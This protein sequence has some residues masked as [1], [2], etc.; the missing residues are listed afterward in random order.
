VSIS[1]TLFCW[2]SLRN[3]FTKTLFATGCFYKSRTFLAMILQVLCIYAYIVNTLQRYTFSGYIQT[4]KTCSCSFIKNHSTSKLTKIIYIAKGK[5]QLQ[6]KQK[7]NIT[8]FEIIILYKHTC[9]VVIYITCCINMHCAGCIVL[10]QD[11]N[12]IRCTS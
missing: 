7:V 11:C 5:I 12:I 3:K 2:C 4:N 9:K 1:L 8:M 6:Y 10:K